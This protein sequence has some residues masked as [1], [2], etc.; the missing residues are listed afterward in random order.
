MFFGREK[1]F[2]VFEDMRNLNEIYMFEI[3]V[4][5]NVILV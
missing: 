1:L 5:C 4:R 3:S 2:C